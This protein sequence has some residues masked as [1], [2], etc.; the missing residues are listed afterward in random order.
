MLRLLMLRLRKPLL[1]LVVYVNLGAFGYFVLGQYLHHVGDIK[2]AWDLTKCFYMAILT[3]ATVGFGDVLGADATVAG[4]TYNSIFI[5]VGMGVAIYF[6][7]QLTAFFIEGHIS[8]FLERARMDRKIGELRGHV[9]VCGAGD[10]GVWVVRECLAS[11]APTV[12]VDRDDKRL[13]E[14]AAQH[15]SLLF[16][17]G[18]ATQDDTLRKTGIVHARAL[19]A[20]LHS[21][22]DNLFLTLSARLLNPKLQVIAKGVSPGAESK[23]EGVGA[24]YVVTPNR[25]G[26]MRIASQILRPSVVTFLD[27]MLRP[28]VGVRVEEVTVGAGSVLVGKTLQGADLQRQFGLVPVAVMSGPVASPSVIYNPSPDHRIEADHVLVVIGDPPTVAKLRSVAGA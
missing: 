7:A 13:S 21:D 23:L 6:S 9:V 26:G 20:V 22:T 18:D 27:R 19:A 14:L 5:I 1:A 24:A 10:T 25:I 28:G 8:T 17:H 16:L 11:G 3:Y 4:Q 2:E 12:V 15:S